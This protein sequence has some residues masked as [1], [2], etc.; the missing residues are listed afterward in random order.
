MSS[1]LVA[2]RRLR[3][4]RVPA[5]GFAVLV[6]VTAVVFGIAPRLV[7]RV[8]DDALRGVVA[9]AGALSRNITFVEEEAFPSDPTAALKHVDEEGDRLDARIPAGVRS[10]IA[11]RSTVVDSARFQV[12]AETTD[13]TF[14][15]FRIQPGAE[16][17]VRYVAGGPPS[18]APREVE[19]PADLGQYM[20]IVVGPSS[21]AIQV[22]VLQAAI[23]TESAAALHK[24]VGDLVFLTLD[25]RDSIVG[26]SSGVVATEI[27]GIFEVP[28]AADPFWYDD[29]SINHV[30]IRTLGGDTRLLDIGALLDD[31]AYDGLVGVGRTYNVPV[32]L[33]WRH[34][35][36]AGR[37]TAA[38]LDRLVLDVRKLETT[39][40]QG[41]AGTGRLEGVAMRSG[42]LV[43]L[44]THAARWAAASAVLAVVAI[45]PAAVA[46]AALALV[47]MLAA[48]RRRPAIQL[49]RSRGG[50]LGQIVRA[51]VVEGM[52]LAVPA[53]ALGTLISIALIPATS[54]VP[55]IV[56]CAAVAVVA[57]GL[58]LAAALPGTIA[59]NRPA[60]VTEE[61]PR[62]ATA[63]R[64]IFDLVVIA[65]AAGGAWL[66]RE[67][68]VR[69]ASSTGAL[70]TADPLI[71][72]VP[73][74]AGIAIGLIAIRLVR[75]PLW[76]LDRL[77]ARAR[78]IVGFL[79][80]RRAITGG[81]TGAILVVLLAASSIGAFASAALSHLERAGAQAAWH[82]V[83]APFRVTSAAG[84][85]PSILDP[86]TLPGVRQSASVFS[87]LVA[88][89]PPG[90]R[91]ELLAVDL[92][93]Y[94]SIVGGTPA[95]PALPPEMLAPDAPD[96]V[97]P[98]L[99]PASLVDRSDGLKVG[100][101]YPIMVDGLAYR[102]R[103]VAVRD[104]FPTMGPDE[105]FAVA[106]RQ[107][108]KALHPEA[109]LAP[110]MIFVDAPDNALGP[111]RDAVLAAT[112]AGIVTRLSD[113]DRQ[114][115]AS[116]VTAAIVIG[117]AVAAVVAAL[118]AALAVTAALALAGAA[119]STELAHLRMVGLSRG[120]AFRL[121]AV[122]HGPTV[123]L[124]ALAGIA[125]GLGL[126]VLLEPGLGLDRLIGSS[127]VVPF[128]VDPAQLALSVG[129]VLAI[130]AAAIILAGWAQR[131]GAAV[132]ALR[133]GME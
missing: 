40:P 72:G 64:L 75:V 56:A 110:S 37:L 3:E 38:G 123:V 100:Q 61:A 42:L 19:L 81:A 58:L 84:W 93:A 95:D 10:V 20:P 50:T 14:I 23:S 79:A 18:A 111:L 80:I 120:D 73:A 25:S 1:V 45:G 106:S 43:L 65:V 6:L 63:R 11:S 60:R 97:V 69:G 34:F 130:A 91:V 90:L 5:I 59:L 133:R 108:L 131:R 114:F 126:F 52:V 53:A 33:S 41:V 122:E 102:A 30:S 78:G 112:P 66:L 29:Q 77:A 8:G 86:K 117:I 118:Y 15:R 107:Q 35:V 55:T 113:V 47:A 46:V 83:G 17:R 85:L 76:G 71:A 98:V 28:D 49:V 105:I 125:F 92:A 2:I 67:R 99:V 51:V 7:A 121:A 44:T 22:P 96:G 31:G 62:E 104:A 89:G 16:D 129:A 21:P 32:R 124:A 54:D 115:T 82:E 74:L 26:R 101:T 116:P 9:E 13:P 127:L 94:Q 103:P 24:T 87:A 70:A 4:E 57:V 88:M 119:R 39:F 48:R 68:G 132:A 12:R 109:V 36:D 128:G 27:T